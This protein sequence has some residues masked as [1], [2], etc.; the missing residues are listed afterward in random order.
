MS[1]LKIMENLKEIKIAIKQTHVCRLL[2]L[3]CLSERAVA[4]SARSLYGDDPPICCIG[5]GAIVGYGAGGGGGIGYGAGAGGAGGGQVHKI[6]MVGSGGVGKSA[7]TLQFMYDEVGA[8]VFRNYTRERK[9][10]ILSA[11]LIFKYTSTG[12]ISDKRLENP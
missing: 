7:L 11:F 3:L 6:I 12:L 8:S 4:A 9:F 5:D 10:I 2:L 1:D